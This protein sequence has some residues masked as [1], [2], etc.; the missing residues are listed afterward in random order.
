MSA[1]EQQV[2]ALVE[3]FLIYLQLPLDEAYRA[4]IILHLMAAQGIA[5][6]LLAFELPD[7]AEPA[8]I[9]TA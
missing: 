7:D 1:D 6:P 9:F 2:E 3:A 4:G 5:A 8:P